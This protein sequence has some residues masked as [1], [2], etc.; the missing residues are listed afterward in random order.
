M[1]TPTNTAAALNLQN[2]LVVTRNEFNTIFVE[3]DGQ[4]VADSAT[5][6]RQRG[7]NNKATGEWVK[8]SNFTPRN[9]KANPALVIDFL[10]QTGTLTVASVVVAF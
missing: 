5:W 10:M 7:F 9:I 1:T 8:A 2:A 4:L 3:M 6:N